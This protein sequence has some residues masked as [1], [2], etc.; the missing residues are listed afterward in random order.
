MNN[1]NYLS[2]SLSAFLIEAPTNQEGMTE[3]LDRQERKKARRPTNP[4]FS[5]Y[6][7]TDELATKLNLLKPNT[8]MYHGFYD[9]IDPVADPID[10]L[11]GY[12]GQIRPV[13]NTIHIDLDSTGDNGVRMWF[14]IILFR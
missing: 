14:S 10:G 7:P 6:V 12:S 2:S 1:F 13:F 3:F 5:L 11:E 4:V 9:F 8:T